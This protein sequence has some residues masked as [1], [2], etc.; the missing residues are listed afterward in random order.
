MNVS[1]KLNERK[2]DFRGGTIREKRGEIWEVRKA[3]QM[4]GSGIQ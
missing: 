4:V 2:Y 3:I 1:K